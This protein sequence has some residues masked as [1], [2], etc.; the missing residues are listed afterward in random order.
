MKGRLNVQEGEGRTS[1]KRKSPYTILL[2][3]R[4]P[5]SRMLLSPQL[6]SPTT[7]H[8]RSPLA[9]RCSRAVNDI[10]LNLEVY[11]DASENAQS[12][13]I[14]GADPQVRE[15]DEN[16]SNIGDV[17]SDG[18]GPH[19]HQENENNSNTGVD[20]QAQENARRRVVVPNEKR[21]AIFEALVAK[22]RSGNLKGHE[23]KEISEE[24][25]VPLRTVQRIWVDVSSQKTKCGRKKIE[26]DVSTLR[27]LPLSSRITIHDV[28]QHFGISKSKLHSLK[29][30]GII[31]RVSNSIKPYLT[32]KNKKDML[33][34]CVS[35]LGPNSIPHDP[36]FRGL[37][38]Y[39]FIDE[40][41]YYITRKSFRYYTVPGEEQPTRTC[42]NKNY[43]PK[44]M[45]LTVIARPRFDS[46]GHCTFDGKIGCF[47]FVTYEPAR[48]S[49]VNRPAGTIVMKP[50]ESVTKE[51]IRDFMIE[52]VLPAIRAKWP[53]EDAH[54][55]IFIQ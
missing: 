44:I 18:A 1:K 12:G 11:E 26:V 40:K 8:G 25:S 9:T 51:V 48:R 14:D 21:R 33:K 31:K 55:P 45:I 22:A 15:E 37:F 36:V 35:M 16:E 24:F 34:W 28:A 52:K 4:S 47:P 32:D 20:L 42:K 41:W 23:M 6:R 50:I 53:R 13:F 17:F 10:D 46:D 27:D 7:G 49:S 3:F 5:L 29:R 2:L 43:I 38:D 54:K 19:A 30:E 39:L